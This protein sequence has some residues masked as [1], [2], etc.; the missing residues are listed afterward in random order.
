MAKLPKAPKQKKHMWLIS[1]LLSATLLVILLGLWFQI[2]HSHID[3]PNRISDMSALNQAVSSF[4][5]ENPSHDQD[6]GYFEI[7]TGLFIQSFEFTKSN[8]VQISGYIWQKVSKKNLK[9][10]YKPGVVFPEA[11]SIA[12]LKKAYQYDDGE[13]R[14]IGWR[15]FG[16]SLLQNFNYS[17]YPFDIQNI[18]IRVWP[19]DFY[20]Y[21]IITPDLGS[22]VSTKPGHVFALDKDILRQGF[23]LKETYFDLLIK[24]YETSFGDPMQYRAT[25]SLEL[26]FNIIVKRDLLNAFLIHFIPIFGIWCVLFAITMIISNDRQFAERVGLSTTQI[27]AAL[28]G[29]IFAVILMSNNLRNNYLD[30]PIL[31]MEYF[32]LITFVIIIF[33]SYD[34]YVVTAKRKVHTILHHNLLP[35]TMFWPFILICLVLLTVLKFYIY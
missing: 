30:Q 12:S 33:V 21:V 24:H 7:P 3:S 20:H 14:L 31:F 6:N 15:F 9:L 5:Q 11:K 27:F 32:Y 8:T 2:N 16:V 17:N 18:K 23:N 22:Y 29:I 1:N 26:Y 28:A 19:E 25:N 10:G 13:Y 4:I 34:A 35:K